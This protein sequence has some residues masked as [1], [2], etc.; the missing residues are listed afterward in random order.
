VAEV[1][2][3]SANT[4]HC[5]FV[6]EFTSQFSLRKLGGT[7]TIIN[8]IFRLLQAGTHS[9]EV[10]DHYLTK[11]LRGFIHLLSV[12]IVGTTVLPNNKRNVKKKL[13]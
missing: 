5:N 3:I 8:K 10:T 13:N 2:K 7:C 11:I 12:I 1:L 4:Q 6:G 9:F